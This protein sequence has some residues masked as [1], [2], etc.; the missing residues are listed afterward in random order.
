MEP[1]KVMVNDLRSQEKELTDDINNLNKKVGWLPLAV[2][3]TSSSYNSSPNSLRN[4][5]MMPRHN[6][7]TSYGLYSDAPS[8]NF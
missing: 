6:Y 5:L 7:V 1:H 8:R 2:W 3:R 4:S